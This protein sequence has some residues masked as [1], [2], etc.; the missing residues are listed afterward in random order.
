MLAQ[1]HAHLEALDPPVQC[2]LEDRPRARAP[3]A[4]NPVGRGEV[5]VAE[6]H[7]THGQRMARRRHHHQLILAPGLAHQA[8]R[9]AVALDQAEL[10]VIVEHRLH[11]LVGIAQAQIELGA[12]MFAHEGPR[13]PRQQPG[14][15]GGTGGDFQL[16]TQVAIHHA[17]LTRLQLQRVGLLQQLLGA[18]QQAAAIGVQ[19]QAATEALEQL[20]LEMTLKLG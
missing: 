1:L 16:A 3:L 11:H 9:V 6:R 7:A 15:D 19:G 17:G 5:L 10:G 18:R 20:H 4:Q 2:T 8:R 12:R 13:Q 14:A